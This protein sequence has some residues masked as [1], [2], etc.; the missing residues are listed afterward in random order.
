[1]A[2][3]LNPEKIAAAVAGSGARTVDVNSGVEVSPGVKDH[4]KLRA[5]FEALKQTPPP[6]N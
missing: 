6:K 2:G 5:F 4:A 3:G 1:L